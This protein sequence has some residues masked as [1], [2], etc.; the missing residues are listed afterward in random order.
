VAKQKR[1]RGLQTMKKSRKRQE[2][3]NGKKASKISS[4]VRKRGAGPPPDVV[5]CA[6]IWGGK[7]CGKT[8]EKGKGT[9]LVARGR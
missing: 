2:K 5:I 4:I 6:K 8:H 3:G 9:G 7:T 1:R